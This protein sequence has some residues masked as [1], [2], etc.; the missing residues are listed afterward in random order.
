[1]IEVMMKHFKIRAATEADVP[2]LLA[3][4]RELAEY[5]K[6]THR[7]MATESR[8]RKWFF[9]K[10]PVAEAV[11]GDL[12]GEAVAYAAFY[13][14]FSTFSGEPGFYLEDL[15]VRPQFRGKGYGREMLRHVARLARKKGFATISW[16][17]LHWNKPAIGFYRHLGAKPARKDWLVYT[18]DADAVLRLAADSG[19]DA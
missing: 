10:H 1:L 9:G 13:P 11:L 14:T 5:E 7:V 16:S 12:R 6:L 4:I 17:V 8:L 3:L 18:L 15:F 2:A 19:N